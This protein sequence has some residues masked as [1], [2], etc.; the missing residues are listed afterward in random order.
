MELRWQETNLLY[1]TKHEMRLLHFLYTLTII[2]LMMFNVLVD[3]ASNME[4]YDE[5]EVP[6]KVC[7]K[8]ITSHSL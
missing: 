1:H 3:G 6:S 8:F 2:M 4:K 7:N 5:I